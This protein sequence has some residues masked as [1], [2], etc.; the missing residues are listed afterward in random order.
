M[1]SWE[2]V[3]GVGAVAGILALTVQGAAAWRRRYAPRD[4]DGLRALLDAAYGHVLPISSRPQGTP[5]L[6]MVG[7]DDPAMALIDMPRYAGRLADPVLSESVKKAG[8]AY[9]LAFAIGTNLNE[10]PGERDPRLVKEQIKAASAAMASI[11]TA[12]ERLDHIE[13]RLRP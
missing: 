13:R 4:I 3:Q 12:S 9:H 7:C 2:V 10:D 1:S 6:E 11:K 5:S 8:F